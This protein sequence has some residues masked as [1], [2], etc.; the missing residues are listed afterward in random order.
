[1]KRVFC[2]LVALSLVS[3]LAG[4]VVAAEGYSK[5]KAHA[6]KRKAKQRESA[7]DTYY[8]QDADKL[9]YGTRIWWEQMDREGRGGGQEGGPS[10]D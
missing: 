3:G 1:M 4:P 6:K 8:E 9:P 2:A 5:K 10:L 7:A